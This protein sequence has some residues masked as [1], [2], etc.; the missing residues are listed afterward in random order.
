[1]CETFHLVV[2]AKDA[3]VKAQTGVVC[4]F[5]SWPL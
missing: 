3:A 1:M 4:R 5:V 2:Q